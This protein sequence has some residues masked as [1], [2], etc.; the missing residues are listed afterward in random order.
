AVLAL[1]VG[2]V[3]YFVVKYKHRQRITRQESTIMALDFERQLA[4]SQLEMQEETFLSVSQEIHDNIGQLLS[5]AKLN[6]AMEISS[7]TVSSKL[8]DTHQLVSKAIV[9]LR[10]LAHMLDPDYILKTGLRKIL[11]DEVERLRHLGITDINLDMSE[12]R[13][14]ADPKKEL[15]IFRVFQ[16]AINNIIKHANA[17]SVVVSLTYLSDTIE[18]R[19]SD[20]GDGFRFSTDSASGTGLRNM[21]RRTD[22]IGGLFELESAPGKGTSIRVSVPQ[23]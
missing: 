12:N 7:S 22:L 19:V 5:L 20:N 14:H 21:S 1:M 18:L 9:D 10:N 4:E 2:F 6:L 15:I 3:I 23:N 13:G 17:S 11:Y 8:V 16:E